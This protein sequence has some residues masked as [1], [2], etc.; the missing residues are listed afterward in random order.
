M[1]VFRPPMVRA[2]PCCWLKMIYVF[3]G[4]RSVL[5][6]MFRNQNNSC[7]GL[8][9]SRKETE[10]PAERQQELARASAS[11]SEARQSQLFHRTS[12]ETVAGSATDL[13]T[14]C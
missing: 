10:D 12:T 9:K 14:G 1:L 5:D 7:S 6:E 3:G 8:R 2:Q 11:V 4:R 13:V